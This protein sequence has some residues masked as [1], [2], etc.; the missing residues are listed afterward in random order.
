[1]MQL[2]PVSEFVGTPSEGHW[3]SMDRPRE[4]ADNRIC[5]RGNAGRG[6]EEPHETRPGK[7]QDS[8]RV[9]NMSHDIVGL[10]FH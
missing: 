7:G 4:I 9:R 1:M 2:G 5:G 8:R 10:G 3:F 6:H